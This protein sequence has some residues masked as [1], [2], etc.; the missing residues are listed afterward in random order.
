MIPAPTHWSATAAGDLQTRN[1]DAYLWLGDE[2]TLGNGYLWLVIDGEGGPGVGDLASAMLVTTVGELYPELIDLHQDPIASLRVA[3]AEANQRLEAIASVYPSLAGLRASFAAVALFQDRFHAVHAGNARVYRASLGQIKA[4]G[5]DNI[6]RS[7]RAIDDADPVPRTGL[8]A[9]G[10]TFEVI[11]PFALGDDI[12]LLCTD[13]VH[14]VVPDEILHQALLRLATHD[15]TKVILELAKQRWGDDDASVSTVRVSDPPLGALTTPE[16]FLRW[17]GSGM[18]EWPEQTLLLQTRVPRAEEPP[19]RTNVTKLPTIEG[20]PSTTENEAKSIIESTVAFSPAQIQMILGESDNEA[21]TATPDSSPEPAK[22]AAPG[23]AGPAKTAETQMFSVDQLEAALGAARGEDADIPFAETQAIDLLGGDDASPSTTVAEATSDGRDGDH[24]A[25]GQE[26]AHS[27]E[28]RPEPG[29]SM[30]S[31][32]EVK[33]R[34]VAGTMFFSPQDLDE[35]KAQLAEN[36]QTLESAE[37]AAFE[38]PTHQTQPEQATPPRPTSDLEEI[39]GERD[40][41]ADETTLQRE[42]LT[43]DQVLGG[44]SVRLLALAFFGIAAIAVGVA[45]WFYL[46]S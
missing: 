12:L 35:A 32:T 10:D 28:E 3:A 21:E 44:G 46:R 1:E 20:A 5:N 8:G 23:P 39:S 42:G 22:V 6:T 7:S 25:R 24:E 33:P 29:D 16:A 15:A 11:E 13:G 43:D 9:T 4:L 34:A 26:P 31:R 45:A 14:A 41:A 19:A 18:T 27:V 37:T 17:A 2:D 30:G 36:T 40:R 38:A